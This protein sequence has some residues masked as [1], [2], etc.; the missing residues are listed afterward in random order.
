MNYTTANME[1]GDNQAQ[2]R[3]SDLNELT[4]RG[5]IF[6]IDQ[7]QL[8]T[9]TILIATAFFLSFSNPLLMEGLF[10]YISPLKPS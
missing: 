6:H 7:K 9:S 2:I 8:S 5:D 10:H 1:S 4:I 3:V